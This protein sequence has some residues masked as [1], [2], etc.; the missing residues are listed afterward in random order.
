MKLLTVVDSSS[1]PSS[2]PRTPVD[3][4]CLATNSCR[5]WLRWFWWWWFMFADTSAST[6]N[7]MDNCINRMFGQLQAVDAVARCCSLL[8]VYAWKTIGRRS[9][10]I[11]SI[12]LIDETRRWSWRDVSFD[13]TLVWKG[14]DV[15]RGFPG[16]CLFRWSLCE[17]NVS[18]SCAVAAIK[19][20]FGR[21]KPLV[22]VCE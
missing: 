2:G 9:P 13:F 12:V 5:R 22:A 16:G 19:T 17:P 21:M 8:E 6:G 18:Q 10:M 1:P 15:K 3:D 11:G 7:T 14:I 20:M 4:F